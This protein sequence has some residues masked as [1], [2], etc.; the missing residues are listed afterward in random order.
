MQVRRRL[1]LSLGLLLLALTAG[2]EEERWYSI[3]MGGSKVGHRH[4]VVRPGAEPG[5]RVRETTTDMTMKRYGSEIRV[6]SFGSVVED[7]QGRPLQF[8]NRLKMSRQ[9]TIYGGKIADGKLRFVI[10]LMG[11]ETAKDVDFP[12][13]SLVTGQEEQLSKRLGLE[14]G[15][16]ITGRVFT[17]EL[18]KMATVELEVLGE[19]EVELPGGKAKLTKIKSTQDLLP[20]MITHSWVDAAGVSQKEQASI[21]DYTAYLASKE[22]ALAPG[23]K[24][25]GDIGFG[26]MVK[27]NVDIARPYE[28]TDALY[29]LKVKSGDFTGMM[30][31]DARQKIE[32]RGEGWVKLRV[33][34]LVP[35][36]GKAV[37][38]PVTAPG[39]KS[40]LEESPLL[41]WKDEKIVKAT[42]EALGG[43]TDAW[44]AARKL[45]D[46]VH[47]NIK[48]KGFDIGFAG[49]S[50]VIRDRA[51][52][53]SEHGVLLAAM[54]RAAGIPSRVVVGL[55]YVPGQFGYH[56]WTEAWAGDWFAL[57][58]TQG[59]GRVDATHIALGI[60]E[61]REQE[62]GL[63]AFTGILSAMGRLELEVGE[64]TLAGTTVVA[65]ERQEA[66]KE[67]GGMLR[68]ALYPIA[69][70][71]P[72]GWKVKQTGTADYLL[73]V[74]RLGTDED[75]KLKVAA[76]PAGMK[77]EDLRQQIAA[78]APEDAESL[79]E[80]EVGGRPALAGTKG[81]GPKQARMTMFVDGTT[82]YSFRLEPDTAEGLAGLEALLRS[83][84]F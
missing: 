26:M 44:K 23:K 46:W 79:R 2:A 70:K 29:R 24:K 80:I 45:E 52:D 71:I 35:E 55:V 82:L 73:K 28:T 5:Q 27:S 69:L 9:E 64:Y 12:E 17:P 16:K 19:E 8:E 11:K 76:V 63:G 21:A 51:G 4:D 6:E 13:G 54:L 53:C 38:R 83:V 22:E 75:I 59:M 81:K 1:A 60:S 32:E 72:E 65:G 37:Q 84:K 61:E 62:E 77:L 47:R 25:G 56:M 3:E 33:R 50:E 43:E 10:S 36:E 31:E 7:A 15:K 41:S 58:G 20:G 67:E 78:A 48:A 68:H 14:K 42:E 40:F 18:G 30:L 66:W 74:E 39:M 57:D 49:A 34:S